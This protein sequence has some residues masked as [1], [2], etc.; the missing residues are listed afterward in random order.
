MS[1]TILKV[2]QVSKVMGKRLIIDNISFETLGGEV[3]GFLGGKTTTIKMILG[4][5]AIDVGEVEICGVNVKKRF[6]KALAS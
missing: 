4:L 3:F 1:E 5:L 2:H 6:E